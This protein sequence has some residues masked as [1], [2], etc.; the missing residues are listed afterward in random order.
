MILAVLLL[1]RT[2]AGETDQEIIEAVR[3]GELDGFAELYR[4]HADRIFALFTRLI[5]P[6]A[7][8]ED[9]VQ[10]AFV[11]AYRAL[12]NFRGE[13]AFST[14]LYRIATRV[15][16]DFL[17]R[18]ARAGR[19]SFDDDAMSDLAATEASPLEQTALRQELGR[20]FRLLDSLSPK[21]RAAFVLV[22]IEG[23]S[24]REAAAALG[25]DEQ[26]IK[27]RVLAARKELLAKVLKETSKEPAQERKGGSHD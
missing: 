11:E 16:C 19:L 25:A 17:E 15:G 9:L 5:G 24:L 27:Q 4:R 6:V 2:R 21:R 7:E 26:A 14:F 23:L 12:A 1:P 22:A 3:R 13:A 20:A 18:R 8:R 10:E